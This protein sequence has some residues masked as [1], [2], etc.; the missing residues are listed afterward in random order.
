[1]KKIVAILVFF[2]AFSGFAQTF[3][4]QNTTSELYLKVTLYAL[5]GFS[6]GACSEI[7]EANDPIVIHPGSSFTLSSFND[8]PS[9]ST[10]AGNMSGVFTTNSYGQ[11]KCVAAKVE[12]VEG[13]YDIGGF[14]VGNNFCVSMVN[15]YSFIGLTGNDYHAKWTSGFNTTLLIE[16]E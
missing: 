3:T 16:I 11:S 5:G 10:P 8:L 14:Y 7:I 15:Q 1:M 12:V 4:I 6:G 2:C 9:W 13:I